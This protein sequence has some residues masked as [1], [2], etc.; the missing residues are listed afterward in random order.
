MNKFQESVGYRSI[1]MNDEYPSKEE[2]QQFSS[3]QLIQLAKDCF[4]FAL[5]EI[6][7]STG[8][9]HWQLE[10]DHIGDI[11]SEIAARLTKTEDIVR[12]DMLYTSLRGYYPEQYRTPSQEELNACGIE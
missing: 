11:A 6:L 9:W 2:L 8:E 5:V 4:D 10:E 3:E 12:W 7:R 1:W